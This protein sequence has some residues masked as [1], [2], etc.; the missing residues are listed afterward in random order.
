MRIQC[1]FSIKSILPCELLYWKVDSHK[2]ECDLSPLARRY[3]K[4]TS[5]LLHGVR[6]QV[7][8]VAVMCGRRAKL[9]TVQTRDRGPEVQQV[10][11]VN[12]EMQKKC[13]YKTRECV[14]TRM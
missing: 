2:D 8:C 6:K 5:F 10:L 3:M 14:V 9:D 1:D 7:S 12:G 13:G 11:G 4:K